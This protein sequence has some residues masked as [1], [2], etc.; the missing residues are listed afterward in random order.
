[1]LDF[2]VQAV[3]VATATTAVYSVGGW[4]ASSILGATFAACG[5]IVWAISRA[6]HHTPR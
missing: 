1:M 5:L 3:H 2:A 6:V 4:T